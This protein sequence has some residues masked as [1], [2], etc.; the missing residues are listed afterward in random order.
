MFLT[1]FQPI[2]VL[3]KHFLYLTKILYFWRC[4]HSQSPLACRGKKCAQCVYTLILVILVTSKFPA[5]LS[6][7]RDF[8]GKIETIQRWQG[9]GGLPC[10]RSSA[11][12]HKHCFLYKES[13]LAYLAMTS[14]CSNSS[15][16]LCILLK[17]DDIK[18]PLQVALQRL[19][20]INCW[21]VK[22]I[23]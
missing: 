13:H 7:R 23:C 21:L 3:S 20:L 16:A 4:S 8:P 12:L 14:F 19:L 1:I 11:F 18:S 22:N 2:T 17:K 15:C 6:Q 9:Q 10:R 5:E